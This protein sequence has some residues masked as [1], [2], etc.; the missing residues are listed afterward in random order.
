MTR[1]FSS[2]T[3]YLRDGDQEDENNRRRRGSSSGIAAKDGTK[4][5]GLSEEEVSQLLA[6]R[7]A[8]LEAAWNLL[9]DKDWQPAVEKGSVRVLSQKSRHRT[10]GKAWRLETLVNLPADRMFEEVWDRVDQQPSWNPN[11]ILSEVVAR[12]SPDATILHN[13]TAE[14]AGGLIKARDFVTLCVRDRRSGVQFT[15]G[16]A[17]ETALVPP[18]T[19]RFVRGENFPGC[20]ACLPVTSYSCTLVWIM[21][22]DIKGWIPTGIIDSAMAN[23]IAQLGQS[24]QQLAS[25]ILVKEKRTISIADDDKP[26]S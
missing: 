16:A 18:E 20:I 24:I 12:L 9:Q 7:P 6:Q 11:L 15:G 4:T 26:S 5:K 8:L 13:A 22:S 23:V 17:I 3:H 25:K 1:L 19:K 2:L 10:S 14:T 21:D